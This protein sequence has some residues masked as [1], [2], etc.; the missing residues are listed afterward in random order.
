MQKKW[1][2]IWALGLALSGC[3][4]DT[5]GSLSIRFAW[6]V[7][8]SGPVWVWLTVEERDNVEKPGVVLAADG[9][10]RYVHGE[11]FDVTLE[12]IPNGDDRVVI[13]EVRE[14]EGEGLPIRY[15]GISEPF[16]MR[17][18]K[19]MVVDVP[20]TLQV[21][22]AQKQNV[23]V[24][25]LFDG[26]TRESVTLEEAADATVRIRSDAS[27]AAFIAPDVSFAMTVKK[28][29]LESGDG[30][31]CWDETDGDIAWHVCDVHGWDVTGGR[32]NPS[33]GRYY[34]F[35]KLVDRL[36]YESQVHHDSILLDTTPPEPVLSS[37]SPEHASS[38]SVVV[39]IAALDEPLDDEPTAGIISTTPSP[40][41]APKFQGPTRLGT[42][43]TY[44]WLA[45]L[46]EQ[47]GLESGE[48]TF[49]VALEDTLGNR[50]EGIALLDQDGT[51][52]S[53]QLDAL[54][55]LVQSV[56]IATDPE[57]KNND[58]ETVLAAKDGG[59]IVVDLQV[60]EGTGLAE[61]SPLVVLGSPQMVPFDFVKQSDVGN[62]VRHF[63]FELAIS[64]A[65]HAAEEGFWPLHVRLEDL[66]GNVT[67]EPD[68]NDA[69]I[70][71]DFT[72]PIAQCTLIPPP[73]DAGYGIGKSVILQ[74]S[75]FEELQAN[76]LPKLVEHW[77]IPPDPEAPFFQHQEDTEYR[78]GGTVQEDGRETAVTIDVMATDL[79]GNTT[80]DYHTACL[81]PTPEAVVDG[82]RP[83]LMGV[84][85][86][87][88][89]QPLKADKTVTVSVQMD[90]TDLLPETLLGDVPLEPV[91]LTPVDLGA[92]VNEWTFS[93][94]LTGEEG[95]GLKEIS[96][97]GADPAGNPCSNS[98]S[99]ELTPA[100]WLDFVAPVA[101]CFLS[102][103]LA[104][105]GDAVTVS[106][107]T[108]EPL[109]AGLPVFSSQNLSFV[110]PEPNPEVTAFEFVHHVFEGDPDVP[111]WSYSVTLEDL[112]GNQQETEFACAG[113]GAVDCT[114]PAI[115]GGE[116]GIAVS[117]QHV[118]DQG[119]FSV[120]FSIANGEQ[121]GQSPAVLVG[122]KSMQPVIGEDGPL[123]QFSYSPDSLGT[124]ADQE[125][126]FPLSV[127]LEDIAGNQ[128][129]YAP[130]N[131]VFDFTD[132]FLPDEAQI[133]LFPPQG[134]VVSKVGSLGPG[135][136][137]VVALTVDDV[138]LQP[139]LVQME[140][141]ETPTLELPL[142]G[143]P[144]AFQ[145]T[146][147]FQ[148]EEGADGELVPG[149]EEEL[150]L[151][152]HLEDLAGNQT[153][154]Q[155]GT[156]QADT[157]PPLPPNVGAF[158]RMI[159]TRIPWGS[160]ATDGKKSFFLQGK[161]MA[162]EPNATVVVYDEAD[163]DVAAEIGRTTASPLGTFGAAPGEGD[164]FAL[165]P[166][167]RSEIYVTAVDGAGNRSDAD[168]ATGGD[169]ALQVLDHKWVATMGFKK[170]GSL[171]ANPHRFTSTSW[172]A[173]RKG[174]T[175]AVEVQGAA[176]LGQVAPEPIATSGDG[177]WRRIRVEPQTPP[178]RANMPAAYDSWREVVV[179]FGGD[180]FSEIKYALGDTWEWNGQTWYQRTP[181]DPEGDGNPLP[182][183]DHALAFDSVRGRTVLFG[184][185]SGQG[186]NLEESM[187][188]SD[189]WEWDG[190][191][192]AL[193]PSPDPEGDGNP[194]A[195]YGASMAYD[196]LRGTVVLF[197]GW[198]AEAN[199]DFGDTWEWNGASWARLYPAD[200]ATDGTP[201]P[202]HDH[203]MTYDSTRQRIVLNG[204]WNHHEGGCG[205]DMEDYCGHTWEL[206]EDD[207]VA[208]ATAQNGPP[209][210]ASA[211]MAYDSKRKR[212]VL[213]G[214]ADNKE[215]HCNPDGDF[216][217]DIWEWDGEQWEQILPSDPEPDSG[218]TDRADLAFVYDAARQRTWAIGGLAKSAWFGE[219]WAWNG[220]SWENHT[221]EPEATNSVPPPRK[222]AAMSYDTVRNR[223]VMTSGF[224]KTMGCT[225]GTSKYCDGT[226]E[227]DGWHWQKMESV[228][229]L[230]D[231]DPEPRFEHAMAFIPE[232]G[233]TLLFGGRN[234][235]GYMDDLWAWDGQEWTLLVPTDPQ[236]DGNPKARAAHGLAYDADRKR[237][238][239]F[240]GS[241]GFLKYD[242]DT[243]EWNGES[244]EAVT[245]D[246]P[247]GDGQP[248]PSYG[249]SMTWDNSGKQI[250][251]FGLYDKTLTC[252][253]G[254]SILCPD[255]WGWNGVSWQR[256][257]VVDPEQDGSPGGRTGSKLVHDSLRG[258]TFLW[259][260][261]EYGGCGEG[262]GDYCG[263]LW[264]WDGTSW[265]R[266]TPADA[267]GDGSP[268]AVSWPAA[269]YDS[270]RGR[271]VLVGGDAGQYFNDTWEWDPG[272]LALPGHQFSARFGAAEAENAGVLGIAALF[273]VGGIGYDEEAV[274][275]GVVLRLWDRGHFVDAA[276][277]EA[278]EPDEF[279]WRT[280]DPL[281]IGRD[282]ER[283]VTGDDE[284]IHLAV[285][286]LAPNE[287]PYA[288]VRTAYAEITMEYR[289][290]SVFGWGFDTPGST[291]GWTATELPGV[292]EPQA[293]VWEIQVD[294]ESIELVSPQIALP[295]D[296]YTD[297]QL[298]LKCEGP[299]VALSLSWEAVEPDVDG[300]SLPLP[301][302]C[303][304]NWHEQ[305][306]PLASDQW[307]GTLKRLRLQATGAGSND[308]VALDWLY[309]TGP[310][311]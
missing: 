280:T 11:P 71:I 191:S 114:P 233:Q 156:V 120:S 172:F 290:G 49:M 176:S 19:K 146:F 137:L 296:D 220:G 31:E 294:G 241:T 140:G 39:V 99:P 111:Q 45:D 178:V 68:V 74:V 66:A 182:R 14:G 284:T 86:T 145:T 256:L 12:D 224:D 281:V 108:S 260:G 51:P 3:S 73:P 116:D 76:S 152:A 305:A 212:T 124:P 15:Y 185:T 135:A 65:D 158:A 150:V 272:G 2:V 10:T 35:V 130:G 276:V 88:D 106:V 222:G 174:Q 171:L 300:G 102:H 190:A 166:A 195:R 283:A 211:G 7:A 44:V 64:S 23:E 228:D 60:L 266:R 149:I 186:C 230:G 194:T 110:E 292:P 279:L 62:G 131:V 83:I 18:D 181:T 25:M 98:G 308:S 282:Y 275:P 218:P 4:G 136:T 196:E 261:V 163:C 30:I 254:D 32:T 138:L 249:H 264:E 273:D 177:D 269:A 252:T 96:V 103:S 215:S 113:G 180:E 97:S 246:D 285:T 192:W 42:S 129:F 270:V 213:F 157:A 162:V 69:L 38:S 92:G 193:M 27:V 148:F 295:A 187:H 24:L 155:L 26:V 77:Q 227:Y 143:A 41:G 170:D 219:T 16:S 208:V 253:D 240:G 93:R 289:S 257:D 132:P 255:L 87:P 123:Y 128:R 238:V 53:L 72:P 165:S 236:N 235:G 80:P 250:L 175:D 299:Q 265:L 232:S 59:L 263:I 100:A 206:V 306:I 121:P 91:S 164:A 311:N 9:P 20:V 223:I 262:T 70:H 168:P 141:P 115:E 6:G 46:A 28:V 151:T 234:A 200:T 134:S 225:G 127:T 126:I 304:G 84:Q 221:P 22:P 119:Y 75:P 310:G 21:P 258:R 247:E 203:R 139:P 242:G 48:Y 216:C 205:E 244:W 301:I 248:L 8:P 109:L 179:M 303:K 288:Q 50:G 43:N 78:F 198:S 217:N 107:V 173:G 122:D 160:K 142:S 154:Y 267:A 36:E 79:V 291:E 286:P 167:D 81:E 309:I 147:F 161:E 183:S 118:K 61:G 1:F 259:G 231:G 104:N 63:R 33:D 201:L 105:P 34:V 29:V 239:L 95:S 302:P 204:G 189:T 274:V 278:S 226:W 202:R 207:W 293:G 67:N 54:Y 101:E 133:A 243:W 277:S 214:G 52:I 90:N 47:T 5:A 82:R 209:P 17:P 287:V 125:G 229:I 57:V 40:P 245:P 94:T 188:C 298:R 37:V 153:S 144:S 271:L 13:M 55:P 117:S 184:G 56:A 210:R 307:Q 85:V 169:Q 199:E 297:L 58:L 251:L 197:G 237:L 89:D 112:A 159:Y 268:P